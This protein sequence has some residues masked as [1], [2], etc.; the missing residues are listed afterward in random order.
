MYEEGKRETEGGAGCFSAGQLPF[1][2][3]IGGVEG[4]AAGLPWRGRRCERECG[5]QQ[6]FFSEHGVGVARMP[7]WLTWDCSRRPRAT[8]FTATLRGKHEA[9]Q[10]RY[11]VERCCGLIMDEGMKPYCLHYTPYPGLRLGAVTA[12]DRPPCIRY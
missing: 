7:H 3:L 9:A 11:C 8:P 12:K 4:L 10:K 5:G 1:V 2:R 6:G